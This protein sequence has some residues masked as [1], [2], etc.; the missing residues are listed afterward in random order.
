MATL[1]W[2]LTNYWKMA[3]I[4]HMLIPGLVKDTGVSGSAKITLISPKV[5]NEAQR[6]HFSAHRATPF[7]ARPFELMHAAA[8]TNRIDK[9]YGVV[10]SNGRD[11]YFNSIKLHLWKCAT[12]WIAFSQILPRDFYA[13]TLDTTPTSN[14]VGAPEYLVP[15]I[16]AFGLFALVDL[17]QIVSIIPTTV[18]NYCIVTTV[19]DF[20]SIEE[21]LDSAI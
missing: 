4:K 12:G 5:E 19:Q 13:I 21:G 18:L 14:M 11:F 2:G 17:I 3:A 15:E 20:V 9:L 8:P 6:D 16:L 7:F 10:G 1:T